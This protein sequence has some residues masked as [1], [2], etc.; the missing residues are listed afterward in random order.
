MS[1]IR[2]GLDPRL[3]SERVA[4]VMH[5]LAVAEGQGFDLPVIVSDP[6]RRQ[7]SMPREEAPPQNPPPAPAPFGQT[8]FL[9]RRFGRPRFLLLP[10]LD[11]VAPDGEGRHAFE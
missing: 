10:L 6:F 5:R 3:I 2:L 4:A 9:G 8:R 11:A 1:Q 7:I